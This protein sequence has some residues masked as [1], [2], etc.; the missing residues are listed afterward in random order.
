M[1]YDLKLSHAYVSILTKISKLN[2]KISKTGF[3]QCWGAGKPIQGD[4]NKA[5]ELS[6]P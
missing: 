6:Q 3:Y 5:G 2:G 1:K 4:V